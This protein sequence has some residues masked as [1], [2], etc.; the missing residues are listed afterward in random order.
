MG[1]CLLN[2]CSS[3][4]SIKIRSVELHI[5]FQDMFEEEL[6]KI[7]YK[8]H[9]LEKRISKME[10]CLEVRNLNHRGKNCPNYEP[11]KMN[12]CTE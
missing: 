12:L 2:T 8:I 4:G 3:V 9:Y 5:L 1:H 11:A 10:T 6:E 7:N